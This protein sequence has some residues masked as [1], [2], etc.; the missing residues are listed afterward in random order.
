MAG[1]VE[2]QVTKVDPTDPE[3]KGMVYQVHKVTEEIA[4]TLGGK[5]YR[6]RIVKN[7]SATD[8]AGKVYQIV[9]IGDPD[10]PAV[11][12]KVYNAIITGDG[13]ATV[14]TPAVPPITLEDGVES[15]LVA[16][17]AYGKCAQ[18]DTPT[19]TAPVDIYF[20]NGTLKFRDDELPTGYRRILGMAMNNDCFYQ[21]TTYPRGSDTLKFSFKC[22]QAQPACNV[23]GCYTTSSAQD[24]LSLYVGYTQSTAKYLRYDGG[25]YSSWVIADKRYDVQITPTGS[26]GM[27]QEDTWTEKTFTCSAPLC[28]GITGATAT[29]AKLIGELYGNV[30]LVGVAKFIPC[31]RISDGEIGYYDVVNETF[32]E[33]TGTTPTSLGYDTSHIVSSVEGA[34]ETIRVRCGKNIFDKDHR[35]RI[36]GYFASSGT[37]WSYAT[38]A[39]CNRIPCK[40]NTKYTARYNGSGTQAVLGFGSTSNDDVPP[41]VSGGSITITQAIRQNAPTINTPITLTTGPSDKWLI[42]AYNVAEQQNTDMANNLMVEEGETASNYE[43]FVGSYATCEN[44]FGIGDYVDEQEVIA[45][46]VTR[47]VGVKVLDGTETGWTKLSG[48]NYVSLPKTSISNMVS[49]TDATCLSNSF[50]QVPHGSVSSSEE[51]FTVGASYVNFKKAGD[52]TVAQFQQWLAAQYAAGTPVI[53]VYPLATE[54]T[55]TVAGQDMEIVDGD[56]AVEITQASVDGL[57]VG[58]TYMKEEAE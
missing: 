30:E 18:A 11:K 33:P 25:T 35:E 27:E 50:V 49:G 32:I 6:A 12:G 21:T 36:V 34:T 31:E 26:I 39:Y 23:I 45:G 3:T 55:E 41:P 1:G 28:I 22:T 37:Q 24:N 52:P 43:A 42:V 16:L 10:D 2:Y 46:N 51:C 9:L 14:I 40:P 17:T 13:T 54:T 5:V 15:S 8:V 38:S 56:N 48:V 44:L 47:K 29:S 20:N 58:V 53:I 57:E 4:A 7:P 19:P